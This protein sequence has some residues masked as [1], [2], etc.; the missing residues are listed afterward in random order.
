MYLSGTGILLC[1]AKG[2]KYFILIQKI[3]QMPDTHTHTLTHMLYRYDAH[4][5]E[6]DTYCNT[7]ARWCI[8]TSVQPSSVF[9]PLFILYGWNM[10]SSRTSTECSFNSTTNNREKK[11]QKND[12]ISPAKTASLLRF[13]VERGPFWSLPNLEVKKQLVLTWGSWRAG[14]PFGRSWE[15]NTP[16][17]TFD[18]LK[19]RWHYDI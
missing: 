1:H 3:E 19:G 7:R 4:T 14:W 2:V 6:V 9:F 8:S 16:K 15:K 11:T 5:H 12:C 18:G 17:K 10:F 13:S